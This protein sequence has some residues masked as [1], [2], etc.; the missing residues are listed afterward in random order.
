M[1]KADSGFW[2]PGVS[3]YSESPNPGAHGCLFSPGK[4]PTPASACRRRSRE[5]WQLESDWHAAQHLGK[6]TADEQLGWHLPTPEAQHRDCSPFPREA[7]PCMP[8]SQAIS[9]QPPAMLWPPGFLRS[10]P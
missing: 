7:P 5:Q 3:L 1:P 9:R 8:G 6:Y 2:V 10:L 4:A